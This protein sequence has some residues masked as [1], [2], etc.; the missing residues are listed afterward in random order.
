VSDSKNR[1]DR[2]NCLGGESVIFLSERPAYLEAG[3][4]PDHIHEHD[5]GPQPLDIGEAS[6]PSAAWLTMSLVAIQPGSAGLDTEANVG[7]MSQ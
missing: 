5:D 6:D 2:R 4:L 3:D 7:K 1:G